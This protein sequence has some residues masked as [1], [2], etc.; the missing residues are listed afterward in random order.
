MRGGV[1]PPPMGAN[2][3]TPHGRHWASHHWCVQQEDLS[4]YPTTAAMDRKE[5]GAGWWS[6]AHMTGSEPRRRP[7]AVPKA[8]QPCT[9]G[10]PCRGDPSRM[11]VPCRQ[12]VGNR[13]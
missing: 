9:A 1:C 6:A 12:L 13:Q 4:A 11:T 8:A 2:T 7:E 10:T 5:V 3:H